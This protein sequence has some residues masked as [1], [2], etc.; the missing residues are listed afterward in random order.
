MQVANKDIEG[1][2]LSLREAMQGADDPLVINRL[3]HNIDLLETRLDAYKTM[4]DRLNNQMVDVAI[5]PLRMRD[6]PYLSSVAKETLSA[7]YEKKEG[8]SN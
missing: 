8:S 1:V 5:G 7:I 3:N 4:Q 2:I 6:F